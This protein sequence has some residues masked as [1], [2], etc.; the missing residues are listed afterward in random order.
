MCDHCGC[1]EFGPIS[2][3]HEEHEQILDMAWKVVLK[4]ERGERITLDDVRELVRILDIHVAKEEYGL[5]PKL[6]EVEE[7]GQSLLAD[8]EAEHEDIRRNLMAFE[9][10]RRDYFELAAHIETEEEEL[11][12]LTVFSFDD[13]DWDEL[14][15]ME[16]KAQADEEANPH[17]AAA[18]DPAVTIEA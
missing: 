17:L 8:L 5:Y 12:P 4:V 7:L 16:R 3:L 1:R 10:D 13:D 14:E 2:E 9:Y 6:V 11:F 18:A 15:S